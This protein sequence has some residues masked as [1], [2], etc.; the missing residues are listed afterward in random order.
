MTPVIAYAIAIVSAVFAGWAV[1][2]LAMRMLAPS[3][4]ASRLATSNYRGRSVFLGLGLVWAVWAV[5]LLVVSTTYDALG[6]FFMPE[7]GSVEMGL[8]DGP[9]T[10]P[11]YAI[12]LI[13][14]VA[15]VMFGLIDDVFGTVSDK[16]FRGHLK[17][18]AHGRLTTGGL[19][20]LGI[21]LVSAV[22]AW[23]AAT[24]G[25]EIAGV[26]NVGIR[27][28]WWVAGTFVIALS[29]NLVNLT[30]L[31]PGRALKTY[32]VLAIVG[33]VLFSLNVTRQ[34][35]TYA[36]QIG[37]VWGRADV[38]VTAA[39][40]LLVLLGPVVAVWRAD[41]GERGMLGDAGSNAMGAIAGYLFAESLP[42][43][44][45]AAL[46]VVLLG[47][48]VLS[49]KVSFSS[50]IDAVGPLRLF[51]RLGRAGDDEGTGGQ[52]AGPPT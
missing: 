2:A 34:Y 46:A 20:L 10:M 45:L 44:W 14:V 3:L 43:P 26:T 4:G 40:M 29:A 36:G 6:S 27:I 17:A 23:H 25:A 50:V 21:G 39:C 38:A 51:D 11:L 31:R 48:N 30:D 19:K 15:T 52:D 49:E 8:F 41:L 5:S 13:L 1:P 28:G 12:P 42:L 33:G 16:G 32:S 9:L 22:Y 18:L 35:E 37:A 47:L 7:V 24:R